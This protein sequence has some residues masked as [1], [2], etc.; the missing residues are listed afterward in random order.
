MTFSCGKWCFTGCE[1]P[2][3]L[4]S[5]AS[6]KVPE[7]R[8]EAYASMLVQPKKRKVPNYNF[9]ELRRA[10][11]DIERRLGIYLAKQSNTLCILRSFKYSDQHSYY[12]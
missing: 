3:V 12:V 11:H 4:M 8:F 9:N 1:F 5:Y 7:I 10:L 6:T 2:A